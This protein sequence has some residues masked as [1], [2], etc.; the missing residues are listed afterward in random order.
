MTNKN[1][2]TQTILWQWVCYLEKRGPKPWTVTIWAAAFSPT[3]EH[4]EG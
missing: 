3:P 4:T 1:D 2:P